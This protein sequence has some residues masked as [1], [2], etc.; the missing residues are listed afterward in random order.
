MVNKT[1][2]CVF[3]DMTG[4]VSATNQ[5][6]RSFHKAVLIGRKSRTRAYHH[7]AIS[8][9]FEHLINP[10]PSLTNS[11]SP[12]RL[13]VLLAFAKHATRELTAAEVPAWGRRDYQL[14][15]T[16]WWDREVDV[17]IVRYRGSAYDE[18]LLDMHVKRV[19][20]GSIED[21]YYGPPT[22]GPSA[23]NTTNA[24]GGSGLVTISGG[25]GSNLTMQGDGSNHRY[26]HGNRSS[27]YSIGQGD[28]ID[29]RTYINI[30][31]E[32]EDED[33]DDDLYAPPPNTL[34]IPKRGTSST[35]APRTV[36]NSAGGVR[37]QTTHSTR[38]V[39]AGPSFPTVAEKPP[40][41]P[42]TAAE[43]PLPFLTLNVCGINNRVQTLEIDY[44]ASLDEA[45]AKAVEYAPLG[46][47]ALGLAAFCFE[48]RS[49]G[50]WAGEWPAWR[51]DEMMVDAESNELDVEVRL[52]C[53]Q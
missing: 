26:K 52:V 10:Q 8:H 29:R 6:V 45:I 3:C 14:H 13:A 9:A 19:V 15:R 53:V 30:S 22:H 12:E 38:S 39:S 5:H 1:L 20:D 34:S 27:A 40:P 18:D 36:S 46:L 25:G 41:P 17:A 21:C 51:W 4:S 43:K 47:R 23:S 32:D 7:L 31:D 35:R 50:V 44:G 24:R 33:N 37:P 11:V 2:G 48:G 49:G 28:S 42:P 16:A